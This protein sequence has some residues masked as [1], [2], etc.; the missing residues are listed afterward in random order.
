M[1][2]E[3]Q[4]NE[5]RKILSGVTFCALSTCSD[6]EPHTTMVQPSVTAELNIIILS[7]NTRKKIKNI[8]Q[9]NRVWLTFDASGS[10]K[11]PKVIY[12]KGKAELE[13][14]NQKTFDEFLSYH[15]M[16]TKK[17]CQLTKQWRLQLKQ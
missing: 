13:L 9:N 11:I 5:I 10:F 2:N 6:G 17:I 8:K 4:M 12:I 14:L 7:K 15:G 3:K 16:I 1:M